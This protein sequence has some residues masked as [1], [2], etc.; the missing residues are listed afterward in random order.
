MYVLYGERKF[1]YFIYNDVVV[2]IYQYLFNYKVD[3]DINGVQNSYVIFDVFIYRMEVVW[4]KGVYKIE[5][6]FEKNI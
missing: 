4:F 5:M 2:N 3:F 6:V 1:G